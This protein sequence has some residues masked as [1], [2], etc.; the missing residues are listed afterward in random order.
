MFDGDMDLIDES[1][2]IWLRVVAIWRGEVWVRKKNGWVGPQKKDLEM[3]GTTTIN[4]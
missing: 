3:I 2:E 1:L 4:A